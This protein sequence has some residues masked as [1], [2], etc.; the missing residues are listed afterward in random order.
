L[1]KGGLASASI[2][3]KAVSSETD[4]ETPISLAWPPNSGGRIDIDTG[5]CI[6]IAIAKAANY[7]PTTAAA[8]ERKL[9][10]SR[11]RSPCWRDDAITRISTVNLDK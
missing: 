2:N 5:H 8:W 7:N 10:I 6:G 9:V 4:F 11:S 1:I 3:G